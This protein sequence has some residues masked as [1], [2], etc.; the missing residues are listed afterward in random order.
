M[1]SNMG[2]TWNA[3]IKLSIQCNRI[4]NNHE[5]KSQL[6]MIEKRHLCLCA[7]VEMTNYD[8]WNTTYDNDG[9]CDKKDQ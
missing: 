8:T 9:E 7:T 1:H 2:Q 6:E 4:K 5:C 3:H